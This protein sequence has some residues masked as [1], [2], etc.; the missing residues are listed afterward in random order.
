MNRAR[1]GGDHNRFARRRR[2]NMR[3]GE[4]LAS[5][6]ERWRRRPVSGSR[7]ASATVITLRRP[8]DE[9]KH[10]SEAPVHLRANGEVTMKELS[11]HQNR[12]REILIRCAKKRTTTCLSEVG[13]EIGRQQQGPWKKD[14]DAIKYYEKAHNR[15]DVTLV[16]VRK[17]IGLPKIYKGKPLKRGDHG[18]VREYENDRERL[19][20][21]WAKAG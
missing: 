9:V 21:E 16:V 8:V 18:R 2:L 19:F 14:L 1:T 11:Y 4:A 6:R 12:I 20:E 17:N 10:A 13:R 3:D 7:R 5:A 15:S